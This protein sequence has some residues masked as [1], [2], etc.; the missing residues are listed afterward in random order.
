MSA[1]TIRR[2]ALARCPFS[3]AIECAE[4]FL[5]GAAEHGIIEELIVPTAIG[6]TV[7]DDYTDQVRR[8]D[9]LEF[10]WRPR[11]RGLPAGRALLTVRPHAPQGTELQFS[12][13]YVPPFAKVGQFFDVV[14]GR[15]IAWIT[16]GMLLRRLRIEIERCAAKHE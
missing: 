7:T 12:I 9:A 1:R 5:R 15:Y 6:V 8:H 3:S 11:S 16:C 10:H 14:I 13:S 2:D 4:G